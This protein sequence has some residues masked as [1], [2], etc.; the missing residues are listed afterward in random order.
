M[1]VSPICFTK[2][3]IPQWNISSTTRRCYQAQ[4]R[5]WGFI[6]LFPMQPNRKTY[7]CLQI[8]LTELLYFCETFKRIF[9]IVELWINCY[10]IFCSHISWWHFF[11][12]LCVQIYAYETLNFRISSFSI[13]LTSNSGPMKNSIQ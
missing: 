5:Q 6:S 4:L 8:K 9:I 11:F 7:M 10:S 12:E 3:P 1:F 2:P 13:Y